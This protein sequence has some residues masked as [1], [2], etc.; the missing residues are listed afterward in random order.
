MKAPEFIGIDNMPTDE[1]VPIFVS[2]PTGEYIRNNKLRTN[3][4]GP[5]T[6]P[7]GVVRDKKGGIKGCIQFVQYA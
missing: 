2:L 4:F 3:V 6:G 7:A 5:D 1:S